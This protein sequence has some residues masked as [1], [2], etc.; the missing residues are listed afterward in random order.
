MTEQGHNKLREGRPRRSEFTSYLDLAPRESAAELLADADLPWT[1]LEALLR[2][3]TAERA[4]DREREVGRRRWETTPAFY[5]D[6]CARIEALFAL[7]SP[8]APEVR[9]TGV[10]RR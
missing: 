9:Q 4:E 6:A 10:R 5:A 2:E 7:P 1:P 3:L 8:P